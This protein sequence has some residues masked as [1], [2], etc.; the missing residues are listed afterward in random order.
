MSDLRALQSHALS[1]MDVAVL[2]AEAR[3][4]HTPIVW[5]NEA[6]TRNSGWT[7][8][9]VLGR[10]PSV[11]HGPETDHAV[12]HRVL[13]A[14][15]A[16]RS[17]TITV[18][19]YRK[20]GTQFWNWVVVSPIRDTDGTVTHWVGTSRDVTDDVEQA[21]AQAASIREE[22]R[23]RAALDMVS[24]VSDALAD[25]EDPWVL[26][27]IAQMVQAEVVGWA[28]FFIDDGGLR[29]T[30]GLDSTMRSETGRH[31]MRGGPAD[32]DGR[33][34]P[35]QELL[36]G[37]RPGP[38]EVRLDAVGQG[39]TTQHLVDDLLGDLRHSRPMAESVVVH[40]IVGRSA[41]Q[42]ILVTTPR[43][44]G[45]LEA[46]SEHDLTVLYLVVR[47][48]G[49]A[50]DNVRLYL[51]EHRLAET[52]QRAMLPEQAEIADLDVWSYYAPSSGHAQVGGDWYDVL[53]TSEGSVAVVIGDVVGHDVQAAAVMGQLRA[54]VRSYAH[55]D[56]DPAVV[57]N[58]VDHHVAGVRPARQAS[59]VLLSL[60]R[61]G[62]GWQVCWSRAGHLPPVLVHDGKG[63]GLTGGAGS[64]IGF[65]E[66]NRASDCVDVQP[67][68]FIVLF[69]DGL[70]ERR[71]RPLRA[72]YDDL[73][74]AVSE[75]G[76]LDAAS[77]GERMLTRFSGPTEDD[78][79]VVVVRIPDP[80]VDLLL[81]APGERRRRWSLPSEPGSIARARHSVVRAC[82]SWDLPGRQSAELVVSELVANAVMHGWGYLV[83]RL[84][85][86]DGALRIEVEDANPAP[87]V[88]VDGHSGRIGGYGVRIV[89][90]FA[91]WGW[92]PTSQGKVV[93]A[94][95]LPVPGRP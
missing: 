79:A 82:D 27:K 2:I 44:G 15:R 77:V 66:G 93:W 74:E 28:G 30:S 9:E 69:T 94:Q 78:V 57:L 85:D 65:G 62:A 25:L 76:G 31:R 34:D 16:G 84:Y 24:R 68:D 54:V 56:P 3:E 64:L 13:E 83:L 48:V 72:A 51:R 43:H 46:Y 90:R 60:T 32:P 91:E 38:I 36:D 73:V 89:E 59:L 33:P 88:A 14:V 55:D 95:I 18:L 19:N 67:G 5:V 35:V 61:R 47:R 29:A 49:L 39:P 17:S 6:W 20:D 87:P 21:D 75:L 81:E 1:Q 50:A 70:I 22:R 4:R 26:H 23:A 40:S 52:L 12:T 45:G 42:G 71:T 11:L 53:E 7:L 80:D 37:S 86:V 63:R 10:E 58:R 92:E 8:D 41:V